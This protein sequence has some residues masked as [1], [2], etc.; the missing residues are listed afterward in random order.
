MSDKYN[1]RFYEN[2]DED[3]WDQFIVDSA[4]GT[5]LQSRRFLNYHPVGRFKDASLLIYD[6]KNRLMAVCPACE[7]EDNG[8]SF[9]SHRGS[10][11]GGLVI[12]TGAE[13]TAI[14]IELIQAMEEFL[15]EHGFQHAVLK[16]SMGLFHN[17]SAELLEF[18]LWNQ[19]YAECKE[20]STYIALQE[21]PDD[22]TE[23]FSKLKKRQVKKCIA[24]NMEY[25]EL[26]TDEEIADFH[27]VLAINLQ[28]YDKTPVHTVADLLDLKNNR[29]SED[30]RF[31][32][33]YLENQLIA[34]TMVFEFPKY[35]VAHTQY[36]SSD[37]EYNRL[38]PM[39]YVYYKTMEEYKNRGFRC[40]SWGIST[41][42]DGRIINEGLTNNKEEFG[43]C[44]N[45]LKI[46]KKDL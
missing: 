29:F 28:K 25:R 11:Y 7:A 6:A 18:C 35:G 19:G 45:L 43:S 37:L 2:V 27:R 22:L 44:H 4:N 33:V 3:I 42:D 12:S 10:T 31:Y 23:I 21:T 15:R 38:S 20:L 32:G 17:S 9:I 30:I 34:G 1:V 26:T 41:E 36:L 16:Q 8:K 24:E 14:V 13:R 39:T 5:F 40:L 46:Y